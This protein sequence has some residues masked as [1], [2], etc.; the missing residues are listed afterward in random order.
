MYRLGLLSIPIRANHEI[1][2]RLQRMIVCCCLY[3]IILIDPISISISPPITAR[4]EMRAVNDCAIL[5]DSHYHDLDPCQ[6]QDSDSG[7]WNVGKYMKT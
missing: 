1:Q 6:P 3:V 5:S 7:E 2:Q 4:R